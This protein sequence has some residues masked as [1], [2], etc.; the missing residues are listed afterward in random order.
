M[1]FSLRIA[2]VCLLLFALDARCGTV[3]LVLSDN[4]RPYGEFQAALSEQLA[5][6]NWRITTYAA[7][8]VAGQALAA[9]IVVTAGSEALRRMLAR[10]VSQPVVATLLPRH[11]YEKLLAEAPTPPRKISA[12]YLD[13]PPG[14]QA[15][16]VRHLL[17]D[18]KR[19]GLLASGETRPGL[20]RLRQLLGN[21]GLS[22]EAEEIDSDAT[23]LPA[24]N[25]LLP[26]ID[27]L[28]ASPDTTVYRRGNVK[29]IL[30]TT[31]RHQKPLVGYS[32]AFTQ[33]GALAS[34]FSTPA[35]I[36]RQTAG[37]LQAAP[38]GWPAAA[39]PNLFTLS[40]NYSVAQSLGLRIP[41]EATIRQALL[42]EGEAR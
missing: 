23:L 10:G 24:L 8:A 13:Q 4:S 6:S 34:L 28:L 40:I 7:D 1:R 36:A 22:L 3:A 19:V 16:F 41:E 25:T 29:A 35:Q 39:A 12:I 37:L 21:R 27:L 33:A 20:G 14:R 42:A 15:A 11:G 17:P 18:A 38:A 31:F 2:F 32:E 5:D 30:I 9:D 26:R